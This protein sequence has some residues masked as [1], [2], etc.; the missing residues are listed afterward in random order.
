[1]LKEPE[2]RAMERDKIRNE[3][4]V[5]IAKQILKKVSAGTRR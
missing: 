5:K 3:E 2:D 1:M 4:I